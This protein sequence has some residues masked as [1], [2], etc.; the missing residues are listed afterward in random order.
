MRLRGVLF[1]VTVVP[2][3]PEDHEPEVLDWCEHRGPGPDHGPY[4]SAPHREPLR[5]PLLWPRV[6]GEHRVP[7]LPE[8]G[9]Q[10]GVGP[11]DSPS[12]GQDDERPAPGRQRRRDGPG[13][14]LAPLRPRQRVP[15]GPWRTAGCQGLHE[16]RSPL[17]PLPGSRLGG[18]GRRQGGGRGALLGARVAR[19]HGELQDVGEAARVPV[20][21]RPGQP[22]QFLAQHPL[23]RH[24]LGEGGQRPG[25]FGLGQSLDEEPVDQPAAF[26]PPVPHPVPPGPE[27]H[28]HPHA[29]LGLGVQLLGHGIVEVPVEMEH[30]LVDEDARD[31]QLLGERGSPPGPRLG[32]GRLGLPHALPDERELLGRRTLRTAVRLSVL[33]AH[34]CILTKHH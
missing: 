7:P 1:A 28:P 16:G 26:A 10:R 15:H 25:V 30:A 20:G 32:P 19:W 29:R 9:G 4:G 8:Q 13:Q 3:V 33:A 11:R 2:V 24:D 27:P 22:Q 17:V 34:A 14:L 12:V 5:V 6:G 31:R 21:D 18:R 23:G